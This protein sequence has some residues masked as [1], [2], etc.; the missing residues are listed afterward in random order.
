M[1]LITV[2]IAMPF[3]Y[4]GDSARL[5]RGLRL[6]AGLLSLGF[7]LLLAWRIGIVDGLFTG[8]V[9]GTLH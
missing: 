7:G 3:A 1:M 4:G 5:T 6:A 8:P 2:A 9:G